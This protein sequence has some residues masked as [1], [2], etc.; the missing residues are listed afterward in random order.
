[1]EQAYFTSV[2]VPKA[3]AKFAVPTILS[4][5]V[6]LI[7]NLADTFFVGHTGDPNQVAALTL[8]FPIFMSL[9]AIG[10]LMGVGANSL[11]S[12]S[13][14]SG[15]RKRA[16]SA[17]TF[18]FYGAIFLT[19]ILSAGVLFGMR[20]L[21]TLVGASQETYP[22]TAS[23]LTWTVVVGGIPTVWGLVLGHLIRAEGNSK[24][25]SIG[26]ALGGIMNIVL[27]P[28]L[29]SAA[30]MG[31]TGA[32]VATA[33]SNIIAM[34]YFFAVLFRN[35]RNTVISLHPKHLRY[36]RDVFAQTLLVG[37]PAALVIVLGSSANVVLTHCMAPYG[38]LNVA[39]YGVVQKIGT[40]TIQIT[41]GMT[42]GIMPLI[43]FNYGAGNLSRTREIIRDS[44]ILLAVY[45]ILCLVAI[46]LLPGQLIRAFIPEEN[47]VAVGI[48]FL[49]RWILCAP[50]M[51]FVMLFNSIFQAMGKWKQSMFLSAFRQAL[52]LI[53]LL[54]ILNRVMGLYGLVWSQP[55]SDS[56]SLIMG[57][58]LYVHGAASDRRSV[59]Q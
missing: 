45:S 30:N 8:S 48:G 7:Y 1:M 47:T 26:M 23:Y 41:I 31:V 3:I 46:E 5:M 24:Q 2:P 38:D 53:P 28:I 32:A 37:F 49:R 54:I 4:Q 43:G 34:G 44:V 6:T 16:K 15:D 56:L 20:P 29:I 39:A 17:G 36:V 35:R 12:R 51:C 10:N 25:A 19:V 58:V 52:L 13:L 55:I 33:V 11:I 59:V 57:I 42:Q 21:L 27:D 22:Y 18:G 9:T 50:G 14:G 40:I